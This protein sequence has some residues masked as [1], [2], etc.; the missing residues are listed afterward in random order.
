MAYRNVQMDHNRLD[1]LFGQLWIGRTDQGN[2]VQTTDQ[3]SANGEH[4]RVRLFVASSHQRNLDQSLSETTLRFCPVR[5]H[6]PLDRRHMVKSQWTSLKLICD[7]S[8]R[9]LPCLS[10]LIALCLVDIFE[11]QFSKRTELVFI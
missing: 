2:C 1:S 7:Y 9:A 10:S 8:H 11:I 3:F 4:G 6:C 5:Q